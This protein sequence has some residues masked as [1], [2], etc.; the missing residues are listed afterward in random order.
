MEAMIGDN[1]T[2]KGEWQVRGR[3]I[4]P[5]AVDCPILNIVSTTDRITPAATAADAGERIELAEG[6]VG[7]IVGGRAPSSLWP[8]VADWLSQLRDN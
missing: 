3:L 8:R 5:A 2:G 1:R 6:H 7:M 4:T